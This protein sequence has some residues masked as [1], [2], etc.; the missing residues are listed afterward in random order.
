MGDVAEHLGGSVWQKQSRDGT[1]YELRANRFDHVRELPIG[2]TLNEALKL[3]TEFEASTFRLEMN[4]AYHADMAAS[5][6]HSRWG[7][8]WQ[9]SPGKEFVE[10]IGLVVDG[11]STEQKRLLTTH[12]DW[13][14]PQE[15]WS[16]KGQNAAL[17]GIGAAIKQIEKLREN[18]KELPPRPPRYHFEGGAEYPHQ[19]AAQLNRSLVLMQ[20]DYCH[21]LGQ[22]VPLNRPPEFEKHRLLRNVTVAYLRWGNADVPKAQLGTILPDDISA[23]LRL[24][25]KEGQYN[26]PYGIFLETFV[27]CAGVHFDT[28]RFNPRS[29]SFQKTI[30][31]L[32]GA[33]QAEKDLKSD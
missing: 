15:N 6:S 11:L 20:R 4:E 9:N 30:R 13:L 29:G 1:S 7:E 2:T 18:L 24:G 31:K 8:A 28:Y 33:L 14:V 32:R 25:V 23:R 12:L 21:E 26:S 3:A 22:I 10:A 19:L 5:Q 16:T 27:D 17:T